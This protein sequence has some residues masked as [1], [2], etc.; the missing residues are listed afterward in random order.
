MIIPQLLAD[1]ADMSILTPICTV[2]ILSSIVIMSGHRYIFHEYTKLIMVAP[3][4]MAFDSG[5]RIFIKYVMGGTMI[6]VLPTLLLFFTLQDLFVRSL[7]RSGI[8]E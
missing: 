7:V 5:R 6:A 3:P 1:S 4:M 2:F 8:K